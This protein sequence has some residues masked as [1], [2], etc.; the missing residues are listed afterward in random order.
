MIR[1]MLATFMLVGCSDAPMTTFEDAPARTDDDLR[2]GTS[3]TAIIDVADTACTSIHATTIIATPATRFKT[4]GAI[5]STRFAASNDSLVTFDESGAVVAGPFAPSNAELVAANHEGERVAVA[6]FAKGEIHFS[7]WNV[8]GNKLADWQL[9]AVPAGSPA[10]A[11]ASKSDASLVVWKENATLR[12]VEIAKSPG[13]PTDFAA[14]TFED[15]AD[16][17]AASNGEQYGVAWS[18]VEA[19]GKW[20]ARFATFDRLSTSSIA[21]ESATPFHVTSVVAAPRGWAV[22]ATS[23]G[24]T[25]AVLVFFLDASG[26]PSAPARRY[27]GADYGASIAARSTGFAMVAHRA[28]GEPELRAFDAT[29]APTSAWVCLSGPLAVAGGLGIDADPAGYATV[30]TTDEG[31]IGFALVDQTGH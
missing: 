1:F 24:S 2:S 6:S 18:G 14:H 19:D 31:N 23:G 28:S 10:L 13:S 29:G 22:L 17:A 30:F 4:L 15:S 8:W 26:A 20:R 9:Q 21:F 16:L 11:V 7:R 5:G 27:F 3:P 25:S 12:A